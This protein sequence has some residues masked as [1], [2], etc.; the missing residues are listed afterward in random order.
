MARVKDLWVNA[1]GTKTGKHPANGGN[2]DAKRWLACW[3]D[4]GGQEKTRAFAKKDAARKFADKMEAD[5]E[6]GEYIDPN[7][8]R[9]LFGALADKA[10][11]LRRVGG[12]SRETYEASS[13]NHVKPVF[14]DRP[15]R[16]VKPSEILEWMRSPEISKLAG[17]TQLTAFLIVRATFDLAVAD[18]L[19]RDNPARSPIITP[20]RSDAQP[21][22]LWAAARVWRVHDEHPEPYRPV[23]M[24]AAC[25]GARQGEAFA[26]ALDDFDFE[27]GK[28]RIRRQ[29]Q[30]VGGRW[31]FK[32]PKEGKERVVPL[33]RGLAAVVGTWISVHP[34]QAYSLPW[35]NED[36]T[37][38]ADPCTCLLLFRWHGSDRRT[39]GKHIQ[40]VRF[41]ESVWKPALIRA[42][43]FEPPPDSRPGAVCSAS[44]N[45]NGMHALRHFYSTALQDGGVSPRGVTEFMGH[46]VASLAV[47]FRVYGHVTD[48]TFEQ[49]RQVIDRALFRLRPVE[50]GGTVTEL[51][52]A[53]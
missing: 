22:E 6:R 24:C 2:K 37:I 30:K 20:P 38:A 21:K 23:V 36:G 12:K 28:V 52:A 44:S 26:L 49:G 35:M 32:L 33:A 31:V 41:N 48:E 1:D 43:V 51:R 25:L 40:P 45:G 18:G 10:V 4:P 19:R 16:A 13:R 27:G 11:R 5:A 42:G 3:T 34:P 7:A 50:S 46:S 14:G 47:T 29:V 15:V 8:G 39:H 9:E 17:S 53:R